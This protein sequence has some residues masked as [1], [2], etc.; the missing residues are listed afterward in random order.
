MLKTS[1]QFLIL[2]LLLFTYLFN[3]QIFSQPLSWQQLYAPVAASVTG[4]TQL[5]DNDFYLAT[6]T[7]GIFK[8]TDN[9]ISWTEFNNSIPSL[10]TEDIYST[11]NNELFAATGL[12]VSKFDWQNQQWINLNAPQAAYNRIIVS[13]AGYIIASSNIGIFRST[14]GGASWQA[15]ATSLSSVNSFVAAENDVLFAGTGFGVYKSEDNGDTWTLTGLYPQTISDI[16]ITVTGDIYANVF[17][18]GQGIYRSQDQG[19]TWEQMNAGL[20]GQLT[21]AVAVDYQ[22]NIYAGTFEGGVFQKASGQPAFTQINLHQAVS[23]VLRI[24]ISQDNSIYICSELGG[25]FKRNEQGPEWEQLN[26][27]LPLGH[28]IPLGFDWDDNFYM[29]NFY[30]GF[31]RSTDKGDNWFPVAYYFGGSHRYTFLSDNN[32]LFLGTTVEFAYWGMLLRS[33]DQGENWA[34][35]Q[36]GFPLINPNYPW[37]QVVLDMDADSDGDLFAALNTEGIYRR[38]VTDT[39][40]YLVSTAIPDTNVFS[41]C[42]NSND[43][44]FSGYRNGFI[45][46]SDDKGENWRESLSGFQDY[47][48]EFLK[49]SGEYVFAVLHNY[50]YPHQDSS[51]GLYTYDNGDTWL[52]LNLSGLGSRVNSIDLYNGSVFVAGTDSDGMFLSS[53]FGNNWIGANTGLTDNVIKGIVLNPDGYLLCGTENEGIFKANL[54]PSGADDNEIIP[55]MFSL[56]QN[57]PNPFNPVTKIRFSVP[58]SAV[59]KI[60]VYD[61]LGREIRTLVNEL[62]PPGTYETEFNAAGLASG[63]YFYRI[64]GGSYSAVKKMLLLR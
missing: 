31:L 26:T 37:I 34:Y 30:S 20:S 64:T 41:V 1:V 44:I 19:V 21:T 2:H 58:Y 4:I 36:E 63:I 38:L 10:Y 17:Y 29:G 55:V 33:T 16:K 15:A 28:A 35:F 12:T 54:N 24:L 61:L 22:D 59:V 11:G 52:D 53:D 46:K 49:S 23:N 25:L 40:W 14:D 43:I 18:R 47:T 62:K 9:G 50:N 42:V 48:V 32:Q 5:S 56:Q 51:I 45:Y 6:K 13:P 60:Q 7:L 27:G 39:S 3:G 57:Y 8:S